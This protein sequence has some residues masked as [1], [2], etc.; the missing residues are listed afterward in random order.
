MVKQKEVLSLDQVENL[1]N[2]AKTYQFQLIIL[3]MVQTGMR[4]GEVVNLK[5]SWINDA[6]RSIRIQ[7]NK[8]P[9]E[10]SP[11]RYSVRAVPITETLLNNLRKHIGKRTKGYLFQSQKTKTTITRNGNK[12]TQRTFR[13]YSY[14]SIIKIANK[15]FIQ[16][17]GYKPQDESTHIFR[18]TYASRLLKDKIDLESIR[19]LLGH[20]DIKTTLYYIR[21]LPDYN[22]WEQV[23]NVD[24]MDL[25]VNLKNQ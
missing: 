16:T 12:I 21:G 15:L 5:I 23:R 19:K 25:N 20:A 24:V 11:K 6:N 7:K 9:I 8:K 4:V 22:S 13:R 18:H 1:I 10:W 3:T 2:N 17:L 14:R